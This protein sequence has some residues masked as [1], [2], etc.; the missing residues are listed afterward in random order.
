M[1]FKVP[2]NHLGCTGGGPQI[3]PIPLQLGQGLHRDLD[4]EVCPGAADIHGHN[5][6]DRKEAGVR[7]FQEKSYLQNSESNQYQYFSPVPCRHEWLPVTALLSAQGRDLTINP[8]EPH[9]PSQT[10]AITGNTILLPLPLPLSITVKPAGHL[11]C[12]PGPD[13]K[14]FVDGLP[15]AQSSPA[16]YNTPA[17]DITL[18][19]LR[20]HIL[21][22]LHLPK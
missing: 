4:V 8:L 7:G 22:A 21:D 3:N 15:W 5:Y 11:S 6:W 1:Y 20:R 12:C 2:A 10:S 18:I 16:S 19:K 9:P 13:H 14:S 17:R